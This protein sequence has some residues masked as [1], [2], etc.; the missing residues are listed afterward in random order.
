MDNMTLHQ[1]QNQ[2]AGTG[3]QPLRASVEQAIKHYF[4]QMGNQSVANL[5]EMV[6]AEVEEP[7]L[8]SVMQQ[9]RGN[10][11]KASVMLGLSRGTLRKKLKSYD[12]L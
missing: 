6:L 5:Y 4:D 12:L 3:K 8:K 11:S 9:T 10:Q 7:L 1:Q 2:P